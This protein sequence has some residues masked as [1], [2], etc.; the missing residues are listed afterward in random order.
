MKPKLFENRVLSGLGIL[1]IF[2]VIVSLVLAGDVIINAP[3]GE[4][5]A[6]TINAPTGRTAT[7][8]VCASDSVNKA[9]CDYVCDG[10]DDQVEIQQAI[11]ALSPKGGQVRLSRGKFWI[12]APINIT[13]IGSVTLAGEGH[14]W[15]DGGTRIFLQKY[16]NCSMIYISG[17][18]GHVYFATI[19]D[20]YLYGNGAYQSGGSGIYVDGDDATDTMIIN[21]GIHN[22]SEHGVFINGGWLHTLHNVWSEYNGK[23]GFYFSGGNPRL[24]QCHASWNGERGLRVG[25]TGVKAVNCNFGQNKKQGI[26]LYTSRNVVI[27][28]CSV[29]KNN[30][31]GGTN[32]D[33]RISGDAHNC[34]IS[35]TILDGEGTSTYGIEFTDETYNNTVSACTFR[36]HTSGDINYAG[37]NNRVV[38]RQH[39][40]D[41]NM[42]YYELQNVIIHKTTSPNACNSTYEGQLFYNST[43]KKLM[44]CNSTD[45][46]AI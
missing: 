46:V 13:N 28:S 6:T 42:N 22:M 32:A 20:L 18:A 3:A 41:L 12:S 5:N 19:R 43:L 7:Y 39:F 30:L 15:Y 44:Y 45:W 23:N 26:L 8:V 36:R 25:T 24:S 40:D 2:S 16:S 34:I 9:Q 14:G 33:I 11:D 4:I 29:Y 35:N 27:D 21:V 1:F 10:V 31:E 17:K 38:M 37:T